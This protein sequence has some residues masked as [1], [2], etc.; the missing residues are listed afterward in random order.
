MYG[1]RL[2]LPRYMEKRGL[3][4]A[5]ALMRASSGRLTI[6]TA[7]RLVAA[8]GRPKRVDLATLETLCHMFGA[9]PGDLLIPDEP[10][11]PVAAP[12]SG[13]PA[14]RKRKR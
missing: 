14:V 3:K 7:S 1:M 5:Y 8:N 2:D 12:P 6:T 10:I 9:G 4:N 13:K 11:Q